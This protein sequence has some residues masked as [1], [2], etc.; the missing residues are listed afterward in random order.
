MNATSAGSSLVALQQRR[1]QRGKAGHADIGAVVARSREEGVVE[2]EQL[3]QTTELERHRIAEAELDAKAI[4]AIAD[5]ELTP[6]ACAPVQELVDRR[7]LRADG[8]RDGLKHDRVGKGA[9]GEN[10]GGRIESLADGERVG[11]SGERGK[12]G[13]G[14]KGDGSDV[15]CAPVGLV[16]LVGEIAVELRLVDERGRGANIGGGKCGREAELVGGP[17][18]RHEQSNTLAARRRS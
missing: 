13:S 15:L 1:R 2:H 10:V 6:L 16:V 4:D 9:I 11:H 12:N 5:V 3:R 18:Q 17:L 7:R 14:A 8:D